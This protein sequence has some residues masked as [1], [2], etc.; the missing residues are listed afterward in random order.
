MRPIT[1][2]PCQ[3][4][5]P[6][7]PGGL[8]CAKTPRIPLDGEWVSL[9]VA[10]NL[11]PTCRVPSYTA[12]VSQSIDSADIFD[13]RCPITLTRR[14]TVAT[15]TY[16]PASKAKGFLKTCQWCQLHS[17]GFPHG[18]LQLNSTVNCT[19]AYE[20]CP[21]PTDPNPHRIL[22]IPD[23]FVELNLTR[24]Q[25][26]PG[27]CGRVRDP[28][29][30]PLP[31]ECYTTGYVCFLARWGVAFTWTRSCRTLAILHPRL[32]Y[33]ETGQTPPNA[34]TIGLSFLDMGM[35]PFFYFPCGLSP[36]I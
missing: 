16:P 20:F 12:A 29:L 28:R 4:G 34:V 13:C 1:S 17:G 8:L 25:G 18:T 5:F 27:A 24:D 7:L 9:W 3:N 32:R 19:F 22:R 26:L 15:I 11:P 6:L 21:I 35:M 14:L 23:I 31:P 2:T 33:D 36:N 10:K 30:S